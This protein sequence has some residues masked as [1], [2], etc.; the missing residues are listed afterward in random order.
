MRYSGDD[1]S[2]QRRSKKR[3]DVP[4]MAVKIATVHVLDA[5]A[6]L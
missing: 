6:T 4:I 5:T 2:R 3:C 1:Q